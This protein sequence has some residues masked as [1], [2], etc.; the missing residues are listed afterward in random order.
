M[1]CFIYLLVPRFDIYDSSHIHNKKTPRECSKYKCKW[2]AATLN[3]DENHTSGCL[4]KVKTLC[5]SKCWR[6]AAQP[7]LLAQKNSAYEHYIPWYIVL[8]NLVVK[9]THL[10]V[11]WVPRW[12]EFSL[13][14]EVQHILGEHV[15]LKKIKFVHISI[16]RMCL[17]SFSIPHHFSLPFS[18]S[19]SCTFCYKQRKLTLKCAL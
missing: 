17:P 2:I 4:F 6:Y 7:H 8:W 15:E 1:Y 9:V 14:I 12:I 3:S 13:F 10:R 5:S 16:I 19:I 18:N 11:R